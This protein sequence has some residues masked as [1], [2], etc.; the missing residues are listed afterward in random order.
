VAGPAL[1]GPSGALRTERAG[2]NGATGGGRRMLGR[3]DEEELRRTVSGYLSQDVI[4]LA[5]G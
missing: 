4:E 5:G 1:P 3:A 2:G